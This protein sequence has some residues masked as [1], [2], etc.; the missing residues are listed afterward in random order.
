MC[1]CTEGESPTPIYL[2]L[3]IQKSE[4][5]D[6]FI[7]NNNYTTDSLK[8]F[9]LTDPKKKLI[10]YATHRQSVFDG[11]YYHFSLPFNRF[12]EYESVLFDYGNGD[13]DTLKMVYD[14]SYRDLDSY[15]RVKISLY[16]NSQFVGAFDFKGNKDLYY[17]FRDVNALV[18]SE[19]TYREPNYAECSD[20][21]YAFTYIKEPDLDEITD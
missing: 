15:R 11:D 3:K 12:P 21:I 8:I 16:V 19:R 20:T 2:F 9:S 1:G 18:M 10:D 5:R 4:N 6:F 17:C 7:D 13:T 14:P